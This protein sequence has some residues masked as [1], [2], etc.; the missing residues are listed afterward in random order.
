MPDMSSGTVTKRTIF[1]QDTPPKVHGGAVVWIDTGGSQPQARIYN[2]NTDS[3]PSVGVI[4]Y[5]NLTN[6]PQKTYVDEY[7]AGTLGDS[8]YTRG[9]IETVNF[10]NNV[11]VTSSNT[12]SKSGTVSDNLSTYQGKF[13]DSYRINIDGTTSGG[14][15]HTSASVDTSNLSG[16]ISK[17][18]YFSAFSISLGNSFSYDQE[19]QLAQPYQ[20]QSDDEFSFD[21]HLEASTGFSRTIS[22]SLTC[23]V[24]INVVSNLPHT[25]QIQQP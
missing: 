5:S 4:D 18:D 11:T 17:V 7:A 22:A 19:T 16:G 12:S 10:S 8:G 23:K 1:R 2:P 3:W 14:G 25:H 13:I 20:I 6:K 15:S 9:I 24:D 21:Y